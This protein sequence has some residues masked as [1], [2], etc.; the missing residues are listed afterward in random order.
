MSTIRVASLTARLLVQHAE[1]KTAFANG[2]LPN[3]TQISPFTIR[4]A[5][6]GRAQDLVYPLPVAGSQKKTRLARKSSY[7]EVRLH[8][9]TPAFTTR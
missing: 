7:I 8:L 4:V 2:A 6:D 1:T 3:V 9:D 5:L